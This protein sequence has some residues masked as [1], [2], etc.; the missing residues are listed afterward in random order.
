[1]FLKFESYMQFLENISKKSSGN[2]EKATPVPI[3]NTEVKF[4]SADDTWGAA[5]W[6]SKTSLVLKKQYLYCFFLFFDIKR[7]KSSNDNFNPV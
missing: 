2:S 3:P 4:L 5:P 7:Q 6:E 1:M